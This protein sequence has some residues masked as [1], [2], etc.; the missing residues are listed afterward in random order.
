M[1]YRVE[2]SYDL[3][4]TEETI[5]TVASNIEREL[6]TLFLCAD[7]R[8]K[9]KY[10]SL[11]FNL[12]DPKN[13]RLFQQVV[14]GEVTPQCLVKMSPMELASEELTEWRERENEY[15]LEIIERGELE[16]KNLPITKLTHK[17]EIEIERDTGQTFTLEDLA[18]PIPDEHMKV[19]SKPLS[20]R[21]KDSIDQEK[22]P[23][24]YP[25][26]FIYAGCTVPSTVREP[27]K[28]NRKASRRK[29]GAWTEG[30]R[31]AS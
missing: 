22:R 26:C 3:D 6:F 20:G 7:H 17:G 2:E 1:S 9:R 14:L 12:K 23:L 4:I 19:S 15:S 16:C 24:L 27:V 25:D 5:S 28:G 30:C 31:F 11:N 18:S 8:Y 13:T 10:R 29:S 21:K